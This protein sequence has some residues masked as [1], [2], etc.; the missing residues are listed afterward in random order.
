M[1]WLFASIL[2]GVCIVWALRERQVSAFAERFADYVNDLTAGREPGA[3]FGAESGH[4]SQMSVKLEQ[5]A[6]EQDHLRRQ[7]QLAEANLQIILSSMQ[8]GV[9]VVDSRHTVRVV[10][11]SLRKLFDLPANLF[12]H[13][14]METLR[15]PEFEQMVTDALASGQPQE[16]EL[17]SHQ[18]GVMYHLAVNASPI[19]DAAGEAGV[20]AMF[21][22][23]TRLNQLEDVRR[24]FVANVSHELRT[25]LAIFQGYVENLMDAPKMTRSEQA[26]SFQIL[27]KH[28]QRLNALVEDLLIL[29]RLEAR[30]DELHC[31][32]LDV[33]DFL[34]EV[35]RDWSVRV[36]KK[37]VELK[38]ESEP[39]LP[40]IRADRMRLEQV[41]NNL[42]E[43]AFKYSPEQAT[44]TLGVKRCES[45]IEFS[46]QDQGQGILSTDLP[47]IFER[48]YRADKARSRDIGGT[49]LGL[50]IVKHI[51]QAHGG[52]VE[53]QSVFGKGATILVRLPAGAGG[54]DKV[55]R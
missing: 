15:E 49:G 33:T 44:I 28:S 2:I 46:V 19:R 10:N 24:D 18:G 26:E 38:L 27:H 25:P 55:T 51:A 54:G 3:F 37:D 21:R 47:H 53:A 50:S 12:G 6:Q 34:R 14:V 31:A 5:L 41:F 30:S 35:V 22:D 32:P 4:L 16:R 13:T 48:F 20:V 7:R 36:K 52:S 17:Q 43:N 1:A 45:G 42:L 39:E 23:V 9:V 29:A 8:E 40:V 11:P